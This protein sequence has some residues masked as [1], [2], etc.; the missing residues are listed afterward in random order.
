M[1]IWWDKANRCYV[2]AISLG[3]KGGG[4]RHR[5]SVR[6]RTKAEVKDKLDSSRTT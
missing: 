2:G 4:K 5:P 3:T 1:G 6:C